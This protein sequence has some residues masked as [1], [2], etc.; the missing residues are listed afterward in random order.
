MDRERLGVLQLDEELRDMPSEIRNVLDPVRLSGGDRLRFRCHPGVSCFN[1]CCSNIE[2]ILT[3]Y[4]IL[5][6]RRRLDI[7]SELFLYNYA[8]PTTLAKGQLPVPIMRMDEETGRCPFNTDAGCS[9]Y[10]DRPVTCRYYP[11][12]MALMHRQDVKGE[13]EFYFLI[14]EDFCRGHEEEREWTVFE[15]RSDQGSDGY[16]RENRGWMELILKRRSAG[17]GVNTSLQLSEFFYM[18]STDPGAFRRFIFESTFLKRYYVDDDTQERL[19]GDDQ[20]LTEFAFAWL[21]TVLFGEKNIVVR[22][23]A[24]EEL[25]RRKGKK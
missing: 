6:L 8:T 7:S 21:R 5:R 24:V 25:K 20:Y 16:D 2:I 22:P 11:I 12:G 9:V 1:V 10:E 15:W 19:R 13:E 14:R 3:P 23:E 18:A 17:D 4:D